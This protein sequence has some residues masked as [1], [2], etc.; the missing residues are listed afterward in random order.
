[1]I[2]VDAGVLLLRFLVDEQNYIIM[3]RFTFG[4]AGLTWFSPD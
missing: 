4:A 3:R 1:V 2:A